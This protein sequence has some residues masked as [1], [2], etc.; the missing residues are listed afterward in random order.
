M[1][2]TNL[3]KSLATLGLAAALL[4]PVAAQPAFA[5][6]GAY[7]TSTYQTQVASRENLEPHSD[8]SHHRMESRSM[9]AYGVQQGS[10]RTLLEQSGATGGGG[11]G[12]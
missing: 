12:S 7:R 3:T 10:S 8:A 2:N 4:A 6:E 11:Q 1:L 9:N 5:G